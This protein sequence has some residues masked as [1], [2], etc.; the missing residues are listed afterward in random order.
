MSK[1]N[2]NI[3]RVSDDPK[4]REYRISVSRFDGPSADPVFTRIPP[5]E[6]SRLL[7]TLG[8]PERKVQEAITALER[9]GQFS[10]WNVSVPEDLL[11]QVALR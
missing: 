2:I 5:H 9:H 3:I 8:L 7:G 11:V 6:L 4:V 1:G 10:A